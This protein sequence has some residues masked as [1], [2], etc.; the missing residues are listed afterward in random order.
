MVEITEKRKKERA[1]QKLLP[2]ILFKKIN[3]NQITSQ[4]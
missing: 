3:T 2:Q 1:K 4:I